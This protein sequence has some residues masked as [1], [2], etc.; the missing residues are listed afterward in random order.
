MK[1]ALLAASFLC[2]NMF[3]VSAETIQVEYSRFYSHVKKLD[4]EDTQALQFAFGFVRA[5][6]GYLCGINDAK[7]ITEKQ[8]MPLTIS[9]E[10]R[11][12]VPDDKILKMAEAVVEID[13]AEAANLCDMSVQLETKPAYLS[14]TYTKEE[15]VFLL[16][17]YKSF[18]NAMGS[19]LSF[20]MPTV[21]G[22]NIQFADDNISMPLKDAP[23]INMGIVTLPA[24]WIE[25]SKGLT[26]PDVPLRITAKAVR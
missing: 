26:L 3:Q 9:P 21:D 6:E 2:L 20:M 15:L 13:L 10:N 25:Q 14:K 22:L 24:D 12:T 17:Q 23:S 18:F 11:F 4:G 19:F 1:K 7:I 16:E 8:V 5:G